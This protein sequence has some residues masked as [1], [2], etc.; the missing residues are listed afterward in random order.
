MNVDD[1]ILQRR[2][3]RGFLP[4][5]VPQVQLD[6]IFSLAQWAPSNCNVQ[7][8]TPHVVSGP[9]LKRLC[10]ALIH[11]AENEKPLMPDWPADGKYH[12]VYR[13]RQYDAAARLYNAMGVVRNDLL[14]RKAAYLRNHA[15]FDAPHA[16]FLFMQQPFD[17]RESTDLGIYAQTLMLALTARGIAS[18]AQGALA[19]YAPIVRAH[20]GVT[21]DYRL[22]FGISFG[23]EDTRVPANVART[24]RVSLNEAVTFHRN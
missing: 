3:V 21:D 1:A 20:L 19:L 9:A 14:G 17:A 2:S 22:M 13:D 11:A 12:G 7:L 5:E 16:V 10:Q 6:E 24:Q 23:Y 8:W 4:R 18:C 15:C